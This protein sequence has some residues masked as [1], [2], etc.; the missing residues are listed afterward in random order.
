MDFVKGQRVLMHGIVEDIAATG[1]LFVR[2]EGSSVTVLLNPEDVEP[3][4]CRTMTEDD[5]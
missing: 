4:K 2:P 1:A 5:D 3:E